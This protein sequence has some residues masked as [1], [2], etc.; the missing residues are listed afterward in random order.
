MDREQAGSKVKIR[1]RFLADNKEMQM[2]V[3]ALYWMPRHLMENRS[4]ATRTGDVSWLNNS[5]M[6]FYAHE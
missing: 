3:R 6:T 5:S 2:L 1:Y 4:N